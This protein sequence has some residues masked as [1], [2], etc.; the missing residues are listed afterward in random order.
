[1]LVL[2]TWLVACSGKDEAAT[3]PAGRNAQPEQIWCDDNGFGF[4]TRGT[5]RVPTAAIGGTSPRTSHRSVGPTGNGLDPLRALDGCESF[6]SFPTCP[7]PTSRRHAHHETATDTTAPPTTSRHSSPRLRGTRT[8][9]LLDD[10]DPDASNT[11]AADQVAD[12]SPGRSTRKDAAWWGERLHVIDGRA[13]ELDGWLADALSGGMGDYGMAIDPHPT[14]AGRRELRGHRALQQR[15]QQ[16]WV[17]AVREHRG[18]RRVR[19][20]AIRGGGDHGRVPRSERPRRSGMAGRGD[21][22]VRRHADRVF[23]TPRTS[24]STNRLLIDVDMRCP[25]HSKPE[26]NNCGA[27]DYIANVSVDDGSG[28]FTEISRMI[29]S[30]HRETH[31]IVDASQMLP[32]PEGRDPERALVVGA[33]VERAADGDVVLVSGSESRGRSRARRPRPTSSRA[34]PSARS[35]TWDAS[36]STSRFQPTRRRWSF[37]RSSRGTAAAR[38]KLRGVLQHAA[39]VSP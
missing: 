9:S 8:G 17:L 24:R 10:V 32:L 14:P 19:R 28:S 15:A 12:V 2:V 35:T 4:R 39:R 1:M 23:P 11:A 6:L 30:Y 31:W 36:R 16:R 18:L 27:L 3:R 22:R 37:T 21:L 20:A 13:R 7:L 25:D 38:H 5:R 26:F 29:T 34:A 33:E